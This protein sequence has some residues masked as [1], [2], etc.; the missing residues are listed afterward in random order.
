MNPGTHPFNTTC[1]AIVC[2]WSS[3]KISLLDKL[4]S[5]IW[6]SDN[7]KTNN[8]RKG[9]TFCCRVL[10]RRCHPVDSKCCGIQS[11]LVTSLSVQM[12]ELLTACRGICPLPRS[13]C[14]GRIMTELLV[15]EMSFRRIVRDIQIARFGLAYDLKELTMIELVKYWFSR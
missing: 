12:W 14:N 8:G 3:W 11:E 13:H 2:N 1:L 6:F 5:H 7:S 15:N 10:T 9:I 4:E